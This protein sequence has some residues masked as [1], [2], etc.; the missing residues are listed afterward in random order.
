MTAVIEATEAEVPVVKP[1]T[2]TPRTR[3]AAEASTAAAAAQA[4]EAAPQD[5]AARR[6]ALA[7]EIAQVR[8]EYL[9]GAARVRRRA[10]LYILTQNH[11]MCESGTAEWLMMCRF[12]AISDQE[13]HNRRASDENRPE[14][15]EISGWGKDMRPEFLSA[16]GLEQLLEATRRKADEMRAII[17]ERLIYASASYSV[18]TQQRDDAMA[19]MGMKPPY[20]A[21]CVSG[22]FS[23]TWEDLPAGFTRQELDALKERINASIMSVMAEAGGKPRRDGVTASMSSSVYVA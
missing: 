20:E 15:P 2:R 9:E 4:A 8:D 21:A 18:S 1:K 11:G 12:S 13:R 10:V 14:F 6:E 19:E 22:T 23:L 17:R 16:R 7:A 3:K 5:E